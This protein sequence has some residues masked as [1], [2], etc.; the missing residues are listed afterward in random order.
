MELK[1][2]FVLILYREQKSTPQVTCPYGWVKTE[3]WTKGLV[4]FITYQTT[5]FKLCIDIHEGKKKEKRAKS[6]KWNRKTKEEVKEGEAG[7]EATN[8]K[9]RTEKQ[10]QLGRSAMTSEQ[11]FQ[12]FLISVNFFF[13][14]YSFSK[15]SLR[16]FGFGPVSD[17]RPKSRIYSGMAGTTPVQPVSI[18]KKKHI[19]LYIL[20][21]I[22][23]IHH[24]GWF[25]CVQCCNFDTISFVN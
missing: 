10:Q 22:Y 8:L 20:K 6:K 25:V 21:H 3:K 1:S 11:I 13:S 19:Y 16:G 18:K 2:G 17:Y 24:S 12:R 14:C 15:P 7:D 4:S 23:L 9:L 5:S